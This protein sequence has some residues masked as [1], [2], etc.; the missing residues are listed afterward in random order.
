MIGQISGMF[1]DIKPVEEIIQ[2]LV[3]GIP[4]IIDT[5]KEDCK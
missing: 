3:A 1:K 4:G 2:D 5:I